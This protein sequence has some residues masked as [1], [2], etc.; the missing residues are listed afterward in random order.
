MFKEI[1]PRSLST[2]NRYKLLISSIVPRPIAWVSTINLE[3]NVP[4]LAP[5]SYFTGVCND[6]MTLL[7][8]PVVPGEHGSRKDT[9][10]N[11]ESCGEFVVNIAS[12]N[13][14]EPLNYSA[15]PLPQD[16]SEFEYTGVTP[17]PSKII[18]P[19]R[20]LEAPISFECKL[21]RIIT[22]NEG[23]GGGYVVFGEVVYIHILDG[24]LKDDGVISHEHLRAFGRLEGEWFSRNTDRFRMERQTTVSKR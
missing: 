3:S 4:N 20:V 17:S 16:Q 18:R 1:D 19:P 22:V 15:A 23:P 24:L 21:Q 13:L 8:C 2:E 14:A 7:F 9:L 5:F 6:P 12:D 11:I 10:R